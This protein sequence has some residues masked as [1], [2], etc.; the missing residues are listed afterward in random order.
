MVTIVLRRTGS[1]ENTVELKKSKRL[2]LAIDIYLLFAFDKGSI[3]SLPKHMLKSDA[4]SSIDQGS[5]TSIDSHFAH[6]S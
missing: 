3:H 1:T 5:Q 2:K 4:K 6:K